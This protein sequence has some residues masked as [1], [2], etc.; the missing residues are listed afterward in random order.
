MTRTQINHWTAATPL[1][2]SAAA[3]L[4]A[5]TAGGFLAAAVL[6]HRRLGKPDR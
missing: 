2:L 6:L 3:F 1:V 5:L 4:L